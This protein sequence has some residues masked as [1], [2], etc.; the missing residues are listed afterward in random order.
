MRPSNFLEPPLD[1]KDEELVVSESGKI[2]THKEFIC[3]SSSDSSDKRSV[4]LPKL[5]QP[6]ERESP[7]KLEYNAELRRSKD[8]V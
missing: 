5:N 2:P 6:V 8:K 4:Q 3:R 7:L 1:I